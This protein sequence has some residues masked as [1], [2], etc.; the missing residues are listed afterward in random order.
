MRRDWPLSLLPWL[1]IASG[2]VWA[3]VD[4]LWIGLVGIAVGAVQLAIARWRRRPLVVSRS[5]GKPPIV[6]EQLRW[7]RG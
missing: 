2:A 7:P 1:A 3:I 5:R 6:I 4:S